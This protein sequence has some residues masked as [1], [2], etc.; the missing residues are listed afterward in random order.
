M[1]SVYCYGMNLAESGNKNQLTELSKV[2]IFEK[3][4][5]ERKFSKNIE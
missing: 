5:D 4:Q 2:T 3:K 1:H